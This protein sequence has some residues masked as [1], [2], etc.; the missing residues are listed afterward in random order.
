M[1]FGVT[2]V[3]I[4]FLPAVMVFAMFAIW[5]ERNE[6]ADVRPMTKPVIT[7]VTTAAMMWGR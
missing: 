5:W 2:L 6:P 1:P 7:P 3:A 4:V